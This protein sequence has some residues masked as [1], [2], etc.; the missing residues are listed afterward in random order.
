MINDA[1]DRLLHLCTVIPPL[2]EAVD[3]AG[4]SQKPSPAKWSRKET[5]GHL[6][7]SATYNHQRFVRGQFEKDPPIWYDQDNC[8]ACN[9]YQ[10]IGSAQLI[11][12]W[13]LYNRQL[14]E[15]VRRIP[16]KDLQRTC[17]GKDGSLQTLD[18]LVNDYVAHQEHHLRQIV[19]YS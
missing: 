19:A 10:E 5:L 6:I 9:R 8:V 15:I 16:E 12:F 11:A 14:V 7:D 13:T 18:F 4:F 2:L 1:T 3:E 17:T